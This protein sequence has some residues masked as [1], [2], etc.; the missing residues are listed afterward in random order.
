MKDI[1][2][3]GVFTTTSLET[4]IDI[5]KIVTLH[6]FKYTKDFK[7]SGEKHDFWEIAYVDKGEVGVAADNSGFDLR[8]GEAIFH[9]P[10]EY[11][12]IWAKNQY[13]NII[14][15]SFVCH[16]PAMSFFEN[17]IIKLNNIHQ[18]LLANIISAGEACF[19][20]PLDDVYQTKLNI[21]PQAPFG[22]AQIIKNYIELL[23]IRLIQDNTDFS[24]KERVSRSAT[25]Q[26]ET[27]IVEA[28]EQFLADNIYTSITFSDVLQNVCFS[29][30][31]LTKLFRRHTGMSVMEYYLNLKISESQK[32][33]SERELSFTEVAE[34]LKFSSIHYFSR[35]FKNKIG[36]TPSE[37]EK[38]VK[39]KA[40]L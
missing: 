1:E 25:M 4:K 26:N 17:K 35:I 30:S 22:S 14:I 18:A 31:Y 33:I 13:A 37:Y 16:S 27:R 29:K 15:I 7:F 9:K 34:K 32:L 36:M 38:S 39:S 5:Q 40:V 28:V 6:Y 10:N 20:D 19:S 11:H 12:N 3:I 23:L 2:K 24:R 21:N 8:Q